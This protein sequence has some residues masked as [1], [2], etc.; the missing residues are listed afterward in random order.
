MDSA[1]WKPERFVLIIKAPSLVSFNIK[2]ILFKLKTRIQDHIGED[3]CFL[4]KDHLK[5]TKN[6]QISEYI[7]KKSKTVLEQLT[8]L[9]NELK[10]STQPKKK[11][12]PRNLLDSNPRK[13][14]KLRFLIPKPKNN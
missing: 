10:L 1:K 2:E 4:V 5:N 14:K 8:S 13:P 7:G 12:R 9:C 11:I 3:L 6:S